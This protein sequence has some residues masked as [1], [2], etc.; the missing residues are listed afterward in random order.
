[1]TL[2]DS[3]RLAI[4]RGP[5]SGTVCSRLPVGDPACGFHQ[6]V[7]RPYYIAVE[8]VNSEQEKYRSRTKKHTAAAFLCTAHPAGN[9]FEGKA[10][11]QNPSKSST[12]AQRN[13]HLKERFATL[14]PN[15]HA[16]L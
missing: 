1:M 16:P 8:Q 3:A 15:V 11:L 9:I 5:S 10:G 2:K 6:T 14:L 4:S 13:R 12:A 7:D